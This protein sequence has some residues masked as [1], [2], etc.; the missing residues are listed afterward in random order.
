M[1]ENETLEEEVAHLNA[2]IDV[3]VRAGAD[4]RERVDDLFAA[5]KEEARKEAGLATGQMHD[6]QVLNERLALRLEEVDSALA[7]ERPRVAAACE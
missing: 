1:T 6:L 4:Y 2:R 7:Q 3:L 5:T